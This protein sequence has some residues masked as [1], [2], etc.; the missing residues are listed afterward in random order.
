MPSVTGG[1]EEI[2]KVGQRAC[3]VLGAGRTITIRRAS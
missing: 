2:F 3:A 1:H